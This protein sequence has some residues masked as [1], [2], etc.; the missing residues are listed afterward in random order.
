WYDD[1]LP[2]VTV[3][4]G[5]SF[6]VWYDWRDSPA[7]AC[8]ARSDAFAARSL[9]GGDHWQTLGPLSDHSSDWTASTSNLVPNQGDYI[10]LTADTSAVFAAWADARFGTP[11]VVAARLDRERTPPAGPPSPKVELE[12][13][14]PNP[15]VGVATVEL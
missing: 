13:V 2:E 9:D 1:W 14:R 7:E 8:S 3:C 12:R 11:D 10:A 6:V 4:G 5:Q 15:A